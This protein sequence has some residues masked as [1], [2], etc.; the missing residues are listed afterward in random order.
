MK[1]YEFL[2]LPEENRYEAIWHN[3][4]HIDTKEKDGII[5]QLYAIN[6]FFVE[7]HYRQHNNEIV[8]NLPFKHGIHL[9]KYLP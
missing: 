3:G 5:Y 7:I 8:G 9:E 1:I 6:D 2:S 4:K